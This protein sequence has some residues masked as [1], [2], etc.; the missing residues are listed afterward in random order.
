M[1]QVTH[2]T[3]ILSLLLTLGCSSLYTKQ[4]TSPQK[5]FELAQKHEED[6][7]YNE[8]IIK[9]ED[10]QNKHPYSKYATLSKVRIADIHYKRGNWIEAQMAYHIFQEHHP[11]HRPDYITFRQGMSHAQ[12]LP[13]SIDR[14]LTEASSALKYF[15][16]ILKNYP[17]S[18]YVDKAKK[19]I[20]NI[21]LQLAEK[22]IYIADFYFKANRFK[23]AL[24]RYKNVINYY[25]DTHFLPQALYG[26]GMSSLR[27]NNKKDGK[28]Y[29]K[30]LISL[31]KGSNIALKS[32]KA[33][34]DYGIH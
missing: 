31:D 29:L 2:F 19:Q 22:E 25:K 30:R 26:A 6:K 27:I 11:R 34:L 24:M 18:Q 5:A 12:Q 13:K 15:K 8:A 4:N 32:K 33:L 21:R 28:K 10:V 20:K 14:D 17:E 3:L 9:Y 7:R 23:S 16:R 1:L